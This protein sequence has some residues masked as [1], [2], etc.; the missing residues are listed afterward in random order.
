MTVQVQCPNPACRRT[1]AVAEEHLGRRARCPH[2]GTA[3]TCAATVGDAGPADSGRTVLPAAKETLASP[4]P[5]PPPGPGLPSRVGRFQ[6]RARLGAGAFGAVYRAYDPQ[7]EREVALKVPHPGSLQS[8]TAVERFLREAKAA[9]R[10]RHP[11]IVPVYEAGSDHTHHYIATAFIDG[12]TLAQANEERRLDPRRAAA[13]VRDLAEA[14]AYA[15]AE[16]V[17]H[18]D[19]KPANVMLDRRGAAYLMDF[20]L[21]HRQEAAAQLTQQGSILGT[22]A[23]M[24]PEQAAGQSGRPLPASDQYSL[25]VVLYELLCGRVPFSGPPH[26]V[27]FNTLHREPPPPS[28]VAPTVPPEL[29]RICR[30]AMARR[31]EERYP[32]CQQLADDLTRWLEGATAPPAPTPAP[33]SAVRWALLLPALLGGA[34]VSLLALAALAGVVWWWA[35]TPAPADEPPAPAP[36]PALAA[37]PAA[38]APATPAPEHNDPPAPANENTQ[39]DRPDERRAP[40]P[41]PSGPKRGRPAVAR[42]DEAQAAVVHAKVRSFLLEERGDAVHAFALVG[43]EKGGGKDKNANCLQCHSTEK[44]DGPEARKATAAALVQVFRRSGLPARPQPMTMGPPRGMAAGGPGL[45]GAMREARGEVEWARRQSEQTFG[46]SLYPLKAIPVAK[47]DENLNVHLAEQVLP[48]RMAVIAASFPY[49]QQLEEFRTKLGLAGTAEVL[50]ETAPKGYGADGRPLPAFR[51][52]GVRVQRCEVGP[53]GKPRGE[54]QD[55]DLNKAYTP[56]L[57]RTGMRFEP[58]APEHAPVIIPGLVMPRLRCFRIDPTEAPY[59]DLEARLPHLQAAL[60]AL[61]AQSRLRAAAAAARPPGRD[62]DPFN[63]AAG[64]ADPAPAPAAAGKTKPAPEGAAPPERCLVRVVDVTVQPGKTYRY[65]LQA[66]LANPNYGRED[67]A[68]A[69]AAEPELKAD[70][71]FDIPGVVAMPPEVRY[72]AVDQMEAGGGGPTPIVRDRQTY[73]QVHRWLESFTHGSERVPVGEWVVAQCVIA[74]RGEYVRFPRQVEFP[75]WRSAL[76]EFV[77]ASKAYWVWPRRVMDWPDGTEALL[78]D[79]RGGGAEAYARRAPGPDGGAARNVL[80]TR[81][82]EVLL[83]TP[84]GKLLALSGAD[85]VKDE[86]RTERLKQAWSRAQLVDAT[87]KARLQWERD[88]KKE[89]RK[90]QAPGLNPFGPGGP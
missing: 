14:L 69:D 52:L 60:R 74:N 72:Y 59:P 43:A 39:P 86:Q 27:L 81:A 89:E 9:A 48:T 12:C 6:V 64:K 8:A 29:E 50:R 57:L 62:L 35:R 18:R 38:A 82:Q 51:F 71:W 25:G 41:P 24:A 90:N 87:A 11:H 61:E 19:V 46:K 44:P 56:Y 55:V 3:F 70:G 78:V 32:G 66:R 85:D 45:L 75:Y 84:D 83:L 67:A 10:L 49:R 88:R 37:G 68:P 73:L 76:D 30:K 54:Y 53:D 77:L 26:I 4:P 79:F 36:P 16:G 65:R 42:I 13:V 40:P 15:H 7:L 22:P 58:E 47:L 5:G 23:Y 20:G 21:A 28:A 33:R 1:A 31:P 63:P 2:C 17:V 34:A 80:D